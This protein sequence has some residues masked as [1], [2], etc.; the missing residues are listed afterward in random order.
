MCSRLQYLNICIEIYVSPNSIAN[1]RFAA[2]AV[3][4]MDISN[5]GFRFTCSPSNNTT[6]R[7]C[8]TRPPPDGLRA[9]KSLFQFA[10]AKRRTKSNRSGSV[11]R[12]PAAS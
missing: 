8:W 11:A 10:A 7:Q 2:I 1:D 6:D 12:R 5:G 3:I 9:V 4:D